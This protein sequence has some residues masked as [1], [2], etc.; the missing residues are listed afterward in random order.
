MTDQPKPQRYDKGAVNF[1]VKTSPLPLAVL[2][3]PPRPIVTCD[4]DGC[5]MPAKHQIVFGFW[6]IGQRKT[7]R[8]ATKVLSNLCVCEVHK[9]DLEPKDF[10]ADNDFK[11]SMLG[12]LSARGFPMPDFNS[13]VLEFE[14]IV[15]GRKVDP[16]LGAEWMRRREA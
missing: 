7:K 12:Q 11:A 10:M 3:V 15:K 4:R 13:A 8:P 9:L 14:P 1:G 5:V 16:G 6:R 2:K